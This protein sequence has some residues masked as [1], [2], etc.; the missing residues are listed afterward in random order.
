MSLEFSSLDC[1]R[2]DYNEA[3]STAMRAKFVSLAGELQIDG[4]STGCIA[5]I[6]HNQATSIFLTMS[7]K[8]LNISEL[9]SI[10]EIERE[11]YS[12][13]QWLKVK[14]AFFSLLPYLLSEHS[15]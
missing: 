9:I 2:L 7:S 14:R 3:I 4:H 5:Q 1:P 11:N 10:V 6:V 13:Q 12:P 8:P 15:R